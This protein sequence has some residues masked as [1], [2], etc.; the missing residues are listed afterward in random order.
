MWVVRGFP[1][2]RE[3]YAQ[4]QEE[5]MTKRTYYQGMS[6]LFQPDKMTMMHELW[7][8]LEHAAYSFELPL[9]QGTSGLHVKGWT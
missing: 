3:L 1:F 9:E 7:D 6:A 5:L 2:Y 4:A 8:A